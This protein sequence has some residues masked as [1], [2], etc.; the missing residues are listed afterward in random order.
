MSHGPLPQL[1]HRTAL[2]PWREG[3]RFELLSQG[4]VYFPAMLAAIDGARTQVALELYWME[5]GPVAERFIAA[6]TRAAER[7]VA[8]YVL[9]DA[10]GSADVEAGDRRRLTA[11]GV[12]LAWFNPRRWRK[13][14]TNLVRDHRKILLVDGE[15][16]FVG[17]M[18][19]CA[20]FDGADGWR[21][22]MLRI[23]GPCSADWWLLFRRNWRRWSAV[24]ITLPAAGVVGDER[25]RVVAG[26]RARHRPISGEAVRDISRARG[27]VRLATPYFLPPLKLRRA[28]YR[29]RAAGAAVHLLV[30]AR[31]A[32]DLP[33]VQAASQQYYARLL[34]RGVRIFEY[35]AQTT[36]EKILLADD[37]AMLGS[38]NFDGWGLNW[39][40][41]ANQ[42]TDSP[43][44]AAAVAATFDAD[45]AAAREVTLATRAQ[46][47]LIERLR[48]RFWG[49]MALIGLSLGYRKRVLRRQRAETG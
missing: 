5:S 43:R 44:L 7:G 31:H 48:A 32:C 45:C 16:A 38:C 30:P 4:P 11:A 49:R 20:A 9:L 10:Y 3:N 36:H 19:I 27:Q 46:R 47:S 14:W 35:T 26:G 41:E 37:R 28:L 22:N 21:E 8:V 39:N 40:L 25:G 24:D 33:A 13:G 29:A 17:G 2:Y 23:D 42:S 18:G 6:L 34:R 1:L 15:T 12:H